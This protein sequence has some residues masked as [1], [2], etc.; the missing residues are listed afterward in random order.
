MNSAVARKARKKHQCTLCFT[1][2]PTGESYLYL[3]ITPWMNP[4]N[5]SY[6]DY[7]AHQE[8]HRKFMAVGDDY[9]WLFPLDVYE[10]RSM[11]EGLSAAAV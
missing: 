7:K 5:E 6:S 9:D 11:V 2:I 8:C 3:R 1:S 10:W 4:E